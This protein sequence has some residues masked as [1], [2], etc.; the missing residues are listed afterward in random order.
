MFPGG[1]PLTATVVFLEA[2]DGCKGTPTPRTAAAAAAAKFEAR[3]AQ[4]APLGSLRLGTADGDGPKKWLE[5]FFCRFSVFFP[6][7]FRALLFSCFFLCLSLF[8]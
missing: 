2:E 3:G 8:S 1:Q 7:F 4:A 6:V 5:F